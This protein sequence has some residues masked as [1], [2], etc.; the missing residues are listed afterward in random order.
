VRAAIRNGVRYLLE[1]H[2]LEKADYPLGGARSKSP[3]WF[4]LNFP[5]FYQADILFVLRVLGELGRLR[6]R[7]AHGA[8]DWLEQQQKPNGH[9]RGASP[10]RSRTWSALG[11]AEETNRWVTLQAL[12]ILKRAGRLPGKDSRRPGPT[13]PGYR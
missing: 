10:F 7:G 12:Q 11:N 5:L 3:V 8:L 9:F 6:A 2:H 4:R 1:S 13:I